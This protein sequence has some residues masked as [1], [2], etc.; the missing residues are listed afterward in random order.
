MSESLPSPNKS[1]EKKPSPQEVFATS[2]SAEISALEKSGRI[3][4]EYAEEKRKSAALVENGFSEDPAR[5]GLLFS[6]AGIADEKELVEIF[7]QKGSS[8]PA[9][10]ES[11]PGLHATEQGAEIYAEKI[12]RVAGVIDNL[13][14]TY[15]KILR[16]KWEENHALN[17]ADPTKEERAQTLFA[18]IESLGKAQANFIEAFE[19]LHTS[20]VELDETTVQSII[21]AGIEMGKKFEKLAL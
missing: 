20:K 5:D 21:Q 15:A 11:N 10:T 6:R 17:D 4:K 19:R 7:N 18:A 16:A 2:V 8:E 14:Q 13:I 9:E 3:S 12:D 1:A